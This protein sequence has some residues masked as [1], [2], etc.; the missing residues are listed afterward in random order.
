MTDELNGNVDIDK[1][2]EEFMK[3]PINRMIMERLN[4]C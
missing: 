2:F 1:F 3:N 4:D